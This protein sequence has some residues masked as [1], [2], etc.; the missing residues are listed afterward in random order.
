MPAARPVVLWVPRVLGVAF[1]L[2]LSLFAFDA[3][4][5]P[6]GPLAVAAAFAIHLIPSAVLLVV[7]ALA[8]RREWVGAV[9]FVGAAVFYAAWAQRLDWVLIIAGPLVVVATAYALAWRHRCGLRAGV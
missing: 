1:V 6:G 5:T 8:W 4:D 7:V 3:F 2:F 9:L